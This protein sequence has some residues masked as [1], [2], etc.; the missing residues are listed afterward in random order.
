MSSRAT[1]S[2]VAVTLLAASGCFLIAFLYAPL[3]QSWNLFLG[4][5]LVLA[6]LFWMTLFSGLALTLLLAVQ[7]F[8]RRFANRSAKPS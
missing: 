6:G 8:A 4:S 1:A 2:A 5:V 7:A 3:P